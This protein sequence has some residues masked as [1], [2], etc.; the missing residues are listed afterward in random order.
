MSRQVVLAARNTVPPECH[1]RK[2]TCRKDG[3]SVSMKGT[4]TTRVVVDLDC[5]ALNIP[6][7]RKRCDYLFVGEENDTAWVAPIELKSG[8]FKADEIVDQLQGG[9]DVVHKWLPPGSS[10]HFV[11]VLVHGKGV[12]RK[13]FERLRKRKIRLRNHTRQTELISC[14][15]LLK[16]ALR[17][18]ERFQ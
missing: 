12:H 17:N 11:P 5:N 2:Q 16:R 8:K 3:C 9:A 4:P 15:D 1:C 10:F 13:D 14:G 7:N 18:V 6:P